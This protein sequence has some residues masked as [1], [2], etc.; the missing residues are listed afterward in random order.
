M[1]ASHLRRHIA[2]LLVGLLYGANYSIA[3]VV[4]PH[5]ILP[6]GFIIIRVLFGGLIIWLLSLSSSEKVDWK[7]DGGRLFLCGFFG[8]GINMLFF[9]KGISL[10]TALNSALI[11]TVTPLLVY[12]LSILMLGEH[13]KPLKILGLVLGLVGACL[14]MYRSDMAIDQG[15]WL[16]DLYIFLNAASYGV[17]LVLVK[18]L[19][20]KYRPITVTRW[21]FL[22]GLVVVVPMGY[23]EFVAIQWGEFPPKVWISVFYVVIGVTVIAYLTNVW[24][25]KKVNPGT[26]GAYIYVQPVFASLIAILLFDEVATWKHAIASLLVFA[27]VGLVILNFKKGQKK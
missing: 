14:I 7:A 2:L 6:Y 13:P 12:A 27:G 16:G 26:V 15:N 17:Y 19:L 23:S 22:I 21:I 10:T 18:P 20:G 9:F 25:M 4:T 5:Y 24:A 11:M 1:D 3:K 8:V